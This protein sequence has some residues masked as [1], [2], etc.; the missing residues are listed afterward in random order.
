MGGSGGDVL[1]LSQQQRKGSLFLIAVPFLGT[2]DGILWCPRVAQRDKTKQASK[3]GTEEDL[4]SVTKKKGS[5]KGETQ[6]REWR[7]K[8][9][10]AETKRDSG[11]HHPWSVNKAERSS[12]LPFTVEHRWV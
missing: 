1:F 3:K 6:R 12:Q 2:T 10:Q 8:E 5:E 4:S 11:M 9:E 7:E